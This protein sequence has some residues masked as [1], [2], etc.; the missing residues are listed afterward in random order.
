[1][2]TRLPIRVIDLKESTIQID[3]DIE[4]AEKEY[5]QL[6]SKTTDKAKELKD[7]IDELK[8]E[9]ERQIEEADYDFVE[10]KY[11]RYVGSE[12]ARPDYWFSWCRNTKQRLRE[13]K[14][15]YNFRP[16][17]P[18]H[19]DYVPE[20]VAV[21]DGM[22]IYGDLVFV[23]TP[24]LDYLRRRKE[25]IDMSKLGAAKKYKEFG[26]KLRKGGVKVSEDEVSKLIESLGL[27][28]KK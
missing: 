3:L 15:H 28:N 23:K 5:K 26:D 1:M 10:K 11:I 19:D 21:E 6:K 2:A 22:F 16:V 24:L 18:V 8:K 25:E 12:M 27:S 9:K 13:W 7:K 14:A 20:G 4:E 17:D